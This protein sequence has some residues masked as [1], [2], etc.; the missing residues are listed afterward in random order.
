MSILDPD[1]AR[2]D[3]GQWLQAVDD[4]PTI[5]LGDEE[6]HALEYRLI[7]Q[8]IPN[9]IAALRPRRDQAADYLLTHVGGDESSE[10]QAGHNY[11]MREAARMIREGWDTLTT[12]P[13]V[14]R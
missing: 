6:F 4:P 13:G 3:Y 12:G 9:L 7:G 8:H 11:A 5:E 10:W 2:A 14:E 1:Q